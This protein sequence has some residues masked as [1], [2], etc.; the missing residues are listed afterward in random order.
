MGGRD[1]E[2]FSSWLQSINTF[3]LMSLGAYPDETAEMDFES[4]I[5]WLAF[6]WF[7][8]FFV[9][10]FFILINFFLAIVM[11]AYEKAK[12]EIEERNTVFDDVQEFMSE[13]KCRCFGGGSKDAVTPYDEGGDT[14]AKICDEQRG[15]HFPI[16]I[17]LVVKRGILD[18]LSALKRPDFV[19][20][21]EAPGDHRH[22]SGKLQNRDEI[23]F[24]KMA[25]TTFINLLKFVRQQR[26]SGA[27]NIECDD[28]IYTDDDI[29]EIVTWYHDAVAKDSEEAE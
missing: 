3:L 1:I 9:L 19:K 16:N 10:V 13:C 6:L 26:E 23:D 4:W 7:W 18:A 14:R 24:D 12:G 22:G 27:L 2:G 5:G 29:Q 20:A 8:F 21:W 25:N 17:E 11:E 28:D 15:G